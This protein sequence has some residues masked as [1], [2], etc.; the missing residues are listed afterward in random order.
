MMSKNDE[1]D[2]KKIATEQFPNTILIDGY[3][4]AILGLTIRKPNITNII[5]SMHKIITI[6]MQRDC[7]EYDEAIEFFNYNIKPLENV[8]D[9]TSPIFFDD[10]PHFSLN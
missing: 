3:D 10:R 9:T 8:G 6:L 4:K 5:Y 7:M 2:I 1:I